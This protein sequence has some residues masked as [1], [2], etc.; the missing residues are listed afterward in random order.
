LQIDA[1]GLLRIYFVPFLNPQA[2]P[3]AF[4]QRSIATANS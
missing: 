2:R 3:P 4:V 1:E